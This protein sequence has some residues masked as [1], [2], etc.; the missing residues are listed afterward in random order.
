[1]SIKH[2]D[3]VPEPDDSLLYGRL[4]NSE[5][6]SNLDK[7]LSHLPELGRSEL[8][9]LVLKYPCLFADIPSRTQ[10]IEHDIDMGEA[11]PSKQRF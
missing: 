11:Q 10:W 3:G 1:M 2:E 5:A 4:K 8:S 9:E 7:L 6:L